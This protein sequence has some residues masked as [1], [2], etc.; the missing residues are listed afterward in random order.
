M[1]E[2]TELGTG[3]RT[4]ISVGISMHK[5]SL[6]IEDLVRTSNLHNLLYCVDYSSY[7]GVDSLVK[8]L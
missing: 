7:F 8:C 1:L 3:L 5:Q 4:L 2:V 6:F